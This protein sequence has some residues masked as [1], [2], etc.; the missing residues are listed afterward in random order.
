MSVKMCK[1]ILTTNSKKK[2][3]IDRNLFLYKLDYNKKRL[4]L[5][6]NK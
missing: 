1:N 5:V 2:T 3:S 4:L 6:Y